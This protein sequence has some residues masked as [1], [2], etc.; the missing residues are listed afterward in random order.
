MMTF[1]MF[2]KYTPESLQ[3]ISGERTDSAVELIERHG[4]KVRAMYALLGER[5]LV[6]VVDFPSIEEAMKTSIALGRMT[7]IAFFTNPAVSVDRFDELVQEE[8]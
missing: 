4:G 3:T 8:T 1:L 7:G 5:D 2:G 6:L